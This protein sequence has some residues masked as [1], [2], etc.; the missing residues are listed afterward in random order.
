M[1]GFP[2]SGAGSIA[3]ASSKNPVGSVPGEFIMSL[4]TD[5]I[6]FAGQALRKASRPLMDYRTLREVWLDVGACRGEHCY[7]CVLSNPSFRVFLFEP[8][9]RLAIKLFGL[10]PNFFVVPMRLPK[11]MVARAKSQFL[12]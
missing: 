8:N 2:A 7:G 5:L 3:I 1:A 6:H 10:L 11:R 9:V 4:M 12:C